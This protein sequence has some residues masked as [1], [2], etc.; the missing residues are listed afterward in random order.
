MTLQQELSTITTL[1]PLTDEEFDLL[2]NLIYNQFG[3]TLSAEKRSLVVGRLNKVL[4]QQGF[5]NFKSYYQYVT[6]D[7]T[8]QALETLINR[9]STNH[10]FFWREAD[11]FELFKEQALL[12]V[13]AQL[14]A[15]N[16]KDLRIWCCGC[17]SGEEPYTL[18]MLSLEY[19]GLSNSSWDLGILATDISSR[20]LDRA[21][22]GIYSEKSLENLPSHL[23]MKYF[24]KTNSGD[25]GVIDRVKQLILFRRMNLMRK[26]WPFKGKFSIIF[27]RNVMIYF[28]RPT[29]DD[30]VEQFNQFLENNG[31]LFI[32]HSESLGRT[33][34][35]FRYL[36]P[37]VY[38]KV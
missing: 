4:R 19:L 31:Y 1:T 25:W 22:E 26:V 12:Q 33:N 5:D 35:R 2:R 11:H 17:S 9:V 7:S 20:V 34:Q 36:K 18:A 8:G 30:L 32:G 3:I 27:C 24:K 23:R 13:T 29:R 6:T 38:Q 10:T 16:R 15:Q 14:K 28:D 37:A 21:K